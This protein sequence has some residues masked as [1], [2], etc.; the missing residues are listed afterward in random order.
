MI[1]C[2]D[3]SDFVNK[4]LERGEIK[5]DEVDQVIFDRHKLMGCDNNACPF[6]EWLE[7]AIENQNQLDKETQFATSEWNTGYKEALADCRERYLRFLSS[8]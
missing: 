1:D 7:F 4:L 3:C 8:K 2:K 6:L 5:K